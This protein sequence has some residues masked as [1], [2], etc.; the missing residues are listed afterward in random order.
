MATAS[1]YIPAKGDLLWIDF[2]PTVGGEIGKR[3]PAIVISDVAFNRRRDLC[4][5]APISTSMSGSPFEVVLPSNLTVLGAAMT[6]QL[7][8]MDWRGR[9]AE[10][11]GH[12]PGWVVDEVLD[13][14]CAIL[15]VERAS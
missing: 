4:V 10:R 12:A 8:T 6:D 15:G 3:R 9:K 2:D 7:R 5:V 13:R 1:S 11:A 14:V